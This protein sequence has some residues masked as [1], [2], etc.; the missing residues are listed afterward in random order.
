MSELQRLRDI[1]RRLR[2]PGGCDWDRAQTYSSIRKHTLEETYEVL[3]AIDRENFADLREE[4]GDLLFQVYLYSRMAE[5]EGRFDLEDVAREISDKLVRRH[6]HV[7]SDTQVSGV[8]E[9]VSNWEAIKS[10]EK[11]DRAA[12]GRSVPNSDSLIPRDLEAFLPALLRAEKVQSRAARVGFDWPDVQG[13]VAKVREELNELEE[14]FS[15]GNRN[16][17]YIESIEKLEEEVGDLLFSCV[18]LARR[19]DVSAEVSLNRSI[20][21]F[22]GRF[23]A[24][25]ASAITSKRDLA[26]LS[27]QEWDDLW[28]QAKR[29]DG[30][31]SG[32]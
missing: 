22:I 12:Q 2:E 28:E 29:K 17:S 9:I 27:E 21:K 3:D 23:Q 5:E 26:G 10:R 8:D 14:L 31:A 24:M 11:A 6:P 20:Q 15:E 25:E 4:L 1:T 32:A 13:V 19:L 18:N 7:F 16:S 30:S